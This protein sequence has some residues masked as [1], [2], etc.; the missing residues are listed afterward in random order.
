MLDETQLPPMVTRDLAARILRCGKSI[1][2]LRECCGDNSWVPS[3]AG[4]R[5]QAKL[6]Y[7]QVMGNGLMCL[8]P[9]P[10]S[11]SMCSSL[12][13]FSRPAAESLSSESMPLPCQLPQEKL[14]E[15]MVRQACEDVN[16]RLMS[17]LFERFNFFLHCEA[18]RR[19]MLTAQ[20]R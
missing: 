16:S 1:I 7:G 17:C 10:P 12:I 2:F 4:S 15:Q 6:E 5:H 19:Y 8:P 9:L 3:G 13:S 11:S 14:L 18:I 20:V